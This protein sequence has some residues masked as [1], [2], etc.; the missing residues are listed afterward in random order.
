MVQISYLWQQ[1]LV[2]AVSI[3]SYPLVGQDFPANLSAIRVMT[4]LDLTRRH[5]YRKMAYP[6]TFLRF[7][8]EKRAPYRWL[9]L[10]LMVMLPT[11]S[12]KNFLRN[13]RVCACISSS[14]KEEQKRA[15]ILFSFT[16]KRS[17][18]SILSRAAFA[19]LSIYWLVLILPPL[20]KNKNRSYFQPI[21][22]SLPYF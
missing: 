5:S 15:S 20:L 9:I 3:V 19:S 8:K 10:M 22:N 11:S 13:K 12:T 7:A 4:E 17:G 6:S 2:V 16:R 1:F 14:L 21:S 18:S